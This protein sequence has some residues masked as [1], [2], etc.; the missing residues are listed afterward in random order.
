M[1]GLKDRKLLVYSQASS[2]KFSFPPMRIFP[3][4]SG[5]TPPM[6]MVGSSSAFI[7]I[8]DSMA[9]VVVFPWVPL[10]AMLFL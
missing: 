10:T 3:L 8:W 9:V 1:V 4:I 5:S 7:M 6:E 2:R